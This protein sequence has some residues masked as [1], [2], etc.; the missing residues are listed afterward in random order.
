MKKIVCFNVI[1]YVSVIFLICSM[2]WYI[3]KLKIR[4]LDIFIWLVA[5]YMLID[6]YINRKRL[7]SSHQFLL[8]GLSCVAGEMQR[9]FGEEWNSATIHNPKPIYKVPSK[10][11][12]NNVIMLNKLPLKTVILK[13][14]RL[15]SSG[16]LHAMSNSSR[17][18]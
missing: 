17:T 15:P 16:L 7:N 9:V 14:Q 8:C 10:D 6:D 5:A 13:K 11:T 3:F 4:V 1:F 2:I 12:S 18:L